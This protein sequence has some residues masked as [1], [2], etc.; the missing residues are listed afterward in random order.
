M[1][2]KAKSPV[3][4]GTELGDSVLPDKNKIGDILSKLQ[5]EVNPDKKPGPCE[6]SDLLLKP[7]W[8]IVE[9]MNPGRK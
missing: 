6:V 2:K 5:R 1:P 8:E 9:R 3:P 7:I 4:E